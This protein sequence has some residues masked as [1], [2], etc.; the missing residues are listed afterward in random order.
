MFVCAH[1]CLQGACDVIR[2]PHPC[3]ALRMKAR[4]LH[5]RGG[6]RVGSDG[7]TAA[8]IDVGRVQM[9]VI[10][11]PFCGPADF[12]QTNLMNAAIQ[13]GEAIGYGIA[14]ASR[15][16]RYGDGAIIADQVGAGLG[17]VHVCLLMPGCSCATVAGTGSRPVRVQSVLTAWV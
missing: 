4:R 9:L 14:V 13:L 2:E 12:R 15:R 8:V 17:V 7:F 5:R 16:H 1:E 6:G 10:A 11:L 3:G